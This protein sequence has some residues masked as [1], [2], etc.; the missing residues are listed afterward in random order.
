M[1]EAGGFSAR[2]PALGRE[3][4]QPFCALAL[5]RAL[6][7]L[8]FLCVC[9]GGGRPGASLSTRPP[10]SDARQCTPSSRLRCPFPHQ[11]K[12]AHTHTAQHSTRHSSPPTMRCSSAAP[13]TARRGAPRLAG[14]SSRP[15]TASTAPAPARAL[16]TA[17]IITSPAPRRSVSAAAEPATVGGAQT[18]GST[19]V[20]KNTLLVVGGTGTLGR[21]VVRRALD[22][23]YEVRCIVRPRQNPADFLRDWGATTVQVRR[24][25]F[26]FFFFFPAP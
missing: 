22:E 7:C 19:P 8:F 6:V 23:G 20:P 25:F 11:T 3:R 21:Q 1:S 9:V 12:Y 2:P 4:G 16:S 17:A 18:T 14:A 24:E 15:A 13:A 5:A 10:H 26:F